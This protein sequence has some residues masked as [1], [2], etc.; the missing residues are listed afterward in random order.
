MKAI[1]AYC[2]L[3]AGAGSLHAQVVFSRRDYAEHGRTFAQIWM[4]DAGTLDFRRLTRSARDHSEPVCSRDGK[5]IYFVS[6]RDA[7]RS[8]NAYGDY[9]S[10]ER[11]VWAYDRRTGQERFI[12][13]TSREDGLDLKGTT[14]NGGV[15]VRMGTELRSLAQNPWAI[16]NVDEAAV[17][18]DGRRLALVIAESYD[19]Q[20]QSQNAKLFLADAATGQSRIEVGKYDMPKWSPDGTRIAAFFDGGLAILDGAT[21][22][23]ME[24]VGLPKRDAPSEDIVWSPDGKSLLAGLYGENGGA[25]DPQNDYFLL[26]PA[27]RTWTPEL[28]ARRLL[29]LQ[30][31]TVLYLRPYG[32][33]PLSPGSPH[34]V[35]TSQLAVYDLASHKD[36]G[37]TSGLVL[38]DSL[39]TCGH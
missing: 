38:N 32:I 21:R 35:W 11:E 18:P 2:I 24:R 8:R 26:N 12:W 39:S 30:G 29:W 13:R 34:S 17:S 20:G 15:L 27:T 37:L 3:A 36:T 14:E 7:E 19:K 28:T 6:D 25:G 33:T 23:E 5:L 1:A 22:Q 31:E 9:H 16:D 4:A 10:G